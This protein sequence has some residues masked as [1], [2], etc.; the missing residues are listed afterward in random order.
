MRMF[1]RGKYGASRVEVDGVKFA[2]KLE[3]AVYALLRVREK[4][5]G[6]EILKLQ[7]RVALTTAKIVYVV[8]FKVMDLG[9]HGPVWIEAKGMETPEFK[10]KLRLWEK[11]GPGV[12]EIWKGT[13]KKPKLD[14][15]V[16]PVGL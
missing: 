7:D 6:I 10:L 15:V 1:S 2:S 12:L 5:G 8:D 13:A 4:A 11:Y 14:R 9:T 3:A 16:T